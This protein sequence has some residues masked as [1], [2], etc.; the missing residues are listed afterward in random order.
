MAN[1][2]FNIKEFECES[3]V[4]GDIYRL[5]GDYQFNYTS[6]GNLYESYGLDV[7]LK[8][9]YRLE[10]VQPEEEYTTQPMP[11]NA[12]DFVVG[13]FN[14]DLIS[15]R[16]EFIVDNGDENTCYKNINIPYSQIQNIN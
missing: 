12:S 8:L 9:F 13:P 4:L 6:K 7:S 10:E 2:I 11:Y 14:A 3:P 5:G 16:L 1:I 15:F